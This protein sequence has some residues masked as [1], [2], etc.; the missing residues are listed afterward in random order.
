MGEINHWVGLATIGAAVASVVS[1][2]LV[3]WQ[4]RSLAEQTRESARQAQASTDALRATIYLAAQERAIDIDRY[5]AERPEFR[6]A[7]YGRVEGEGD[8]IELQRLE[9]T[10]EMLIDAFALVVSHRDLIPASI[11]EG[12]RVYVTG[13]MQNSPRLADFWRRNRSWYPTISEF[14]ADEEIPHKPADPITPAGTT[15]PSQP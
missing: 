15:V 6:E 1:L 12:L 10:A 7:F 9:A 4:I 13:L 14:L 5:F 3:A 8:Q 2:I 11:T